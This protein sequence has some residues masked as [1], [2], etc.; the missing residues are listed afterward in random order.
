MKGNGNLSKLPVNASG[1]PERRQTDTPASH[2]KPKGAETGIPVP[3][4]SERRRKLIQTFCRFER[5]FRKAADRYACIAREATSGGRFLPEEDLTP[6]FKKVSKAYPSSYRPL[7]TSI[8]KT[9][10][11]CVFPYNIRRAKGS[12]LKNLYQRISKK[13][14]S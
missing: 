11:K 10:I 4:L 14:S 5:Y 1:T 9:F 12:V 3:F 8:R 7:C 13:H 6:G 2:T